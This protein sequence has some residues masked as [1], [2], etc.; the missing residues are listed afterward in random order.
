MLSSSAA[1]TQYRRKCQFHRYPGWLRV[2]SHPHRI[3]EGNQQVCGSDCNTHINTQPKPITIHKTNNTPLCW[4]ESA[5]VRAR[6]GDSCVLL[7]AGN[8]MACHLGHYIPHSAKSQIGILTTLL[9]QPIRSLKWTSSDSH[10]E[11]F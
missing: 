1:A 9:C 7:R 6:W 11:N 3:R 8:M 2:L 10:S 4:S 5:C